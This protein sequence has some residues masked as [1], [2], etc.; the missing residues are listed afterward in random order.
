MC[1]SRIFENL[2]IL[3][4]SW[5]KR[6]SSKKNI[7]K[8]VDGSVNQVNGNNNIIS[9][10]ISINTSTSTQVDESECFR[11]LKTP[12]EWMKVDNKDGCEFLSRVNNNVSV[13]FYYQHSTYDCKDFISSCWPDN[14]GTWC[15]MNICINSRPIYK[16][17]YCVFDGCHGST[18]V[19]PDYDWIIE[20]N[21]YE[22]I[23]LF[24]YIEGNKKTILNNFIKS[25]PVIFSTTRDYKVDRYIATFV[26]IAEK[27]QFFAYVGGI[28]QEVIEQI[29]ASEFSLTDYNCQNILDGRNEIDLKSAIILTNILKKWRDNI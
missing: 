25:Y 14:S 21:S 4:I 5:S 13:M 18:I 17:Q 11:L 24:Y 29:C 20:P 12:H 26:S 16:D 22:N 15:D 2:N 23:R 9:D 19:R 10:N 8:H 3:P 27:E 7:A 1:L 28:K 6:D